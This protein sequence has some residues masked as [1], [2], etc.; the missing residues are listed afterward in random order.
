MKTILTFCVFLAGCFTI[1]SENEFYHRFSVRPSIT[2]KDLGAGRKQETIIN[3]Y[4]VTIA[5]KV[6]CDN[7]MLPRKPFI[8]KSSSTA[9]FD[10]T[11]NVVHNCQ[12]ISWEVE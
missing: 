8:I 4:D 5:V 9:S 12:T 7:E 2:E 11:S 1:P 10:T 3:P 6:D